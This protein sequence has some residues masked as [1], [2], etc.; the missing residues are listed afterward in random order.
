[1]TADITWREMFQARAQS[2]ATPGDVMTLAKRISDAGD[3]SDQGDRFALA[4]VFAHVAFAAPER[5]VET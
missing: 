1:M 2:G 4:A 5:L 3:A